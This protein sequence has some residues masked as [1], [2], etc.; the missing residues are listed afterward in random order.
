MGGT[1]WVESQAG[2]GS[3]FHFTVLAEQALSGAPALVDAAQP[4]L[5]GKR[6]LV[7][8]DNATN[9]TI[10]VRHAE[11]WGMSASATASPTEALRWIGRGEPFDL[12][13][14]DLQMPEM[15]GRMLAAEIR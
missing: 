4:Q 3:T 11:S 15:D 14:L 13:I 6:L 8:D 10:L 9:R 2:A 5:E 7:V 1:M 12:A